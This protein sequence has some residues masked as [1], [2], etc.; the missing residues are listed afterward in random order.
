MPLT[1]ELPTTKAMLSS[2]GLSFPSSDLQVVAPASCELPA[3]STP[4]TIVQHP[5]APP[6]DAAAAILLGGN[7]SDEKMKDGCDRWNCF[8]NQTAQGMKKCT[9]Q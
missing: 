9:F 5:N 7:P 1:R 6:E 3:A 4:Q 2:G 8:P